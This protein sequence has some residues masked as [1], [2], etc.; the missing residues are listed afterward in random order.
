MRLNHVLLPI[1]LLLVT[2]SGSAFAE[3]GIF[4]FAAG[5]VRLVNLAGAERAARKGEPLNEG[6]TILTGSNGS[7]Q[8]KMADGG[9][10]SVRANTR[11]KVDSY[12][13]IGK[14][15]G[16][17]KSFFSL[18]AG[19]FRALTGLIGKLN[20]D[21]YKITTPSATIG[22]RGTD[23]EPMVVLPNQKALGEPGTYDKVNSGASFIATAKGVIN[24]APNQAGFAPGT[25]VAPVILSR[26]PAF[27]KESP[28]VPAEE[29]QKLQKLQDVDLKETGKDEDGRRK[30]DQ[31]SAAGEKKRAAQPG[32]TQSLESENEEGGRKDDKKTSAGAKRRVVQS[33]ETQA[34]GLENA[35][36]AKVP[37]ARAAGLPLEDRAPSDSK[38]ATSAQTTSPIVPALVDKALIAPTALPGKTAIPAG[39]AP[40]ATTPLLAPLPSLSTTIKLAPLG[41]TTTQPL[42]APVTTTTKSLD[43]L[44][45]P[46]STSTTTTKALD[47]ALTT[48]IQPA[49]TSPTTTSTTTTTK[50]LD[51]ALTTTIQTTVTPPTLTTTTTTKTL[52]PVLTTTIQPVLTAPTT[53][54]TTTSPVLTAPLLSPT[55]TMTTTTIQPVLTTPTTTTTTT[56]TTL[57]LLTA[58]L[59]SPTTTTIKRLP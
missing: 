23:H 16:S 57:P 38:G 47:P 46:D 25:N 11:M 51:P 22:I 43:T 4:Q 52:D 48:T 2:A 13:Y 9:F 59:L 17:E 26:M 45:E 7:A 44:A 20:K 34:S 36:G 33:G 31:G 12:T 27:Y 1:F 29:M 14:Q 28:P 32:V 19:G 56:T 37:S 41:T 40:T 30:D 49:L 50:T 54:T 18:M 6:D 5:D 8:I 55:T 58:P 21:N 3:A 24:I 35:T 39:D 10:I 15:D 42:I 53:T